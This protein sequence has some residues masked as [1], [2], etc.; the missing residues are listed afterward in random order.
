MAGG[1]NCTPPQSGVLM[2][3]AHSLPSALVD[4]YDSGISSDSATSMTPPNSCIP[5]ARNWTCNPETSPAARTLELARA[6]ALL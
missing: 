2:P 4:A 6:F 3:V 1:A 5:P